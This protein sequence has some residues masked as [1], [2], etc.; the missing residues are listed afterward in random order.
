[1]LTDNARDVLAITMESEKVGSCGDLDLSPLQEPVTMA[2]LVVAVQ[3]LP[4]GSV[5][6]GGC[7]D[8]APISCPTCARCCFWFC[9]RSGR[10]QYRDAYPARTGHSAADDGA[11]ASAGRVAVALPLTNVLSDLSI[12]EPGNYVDIIVGMQFVEI[13]DHLQSLAATET[14]PEPRRMIQRIANNVQILTIDYENDFLMLAVSPDESS[15][16]I[17]VG[18]AGLPLLLAGV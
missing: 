15:V 7:G 16:L 10:A 12:Y 2:S 4:P 18:E 8:A 17:W 3:D 9:K 1:M 11:G 14:A 13:D 6:A 5:G